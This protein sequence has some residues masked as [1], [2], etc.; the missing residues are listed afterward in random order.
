MAN[1]VNRRDFLKMS[2]ICTLGMALR[3]SGLLKSPMQADTSNQNILIIIFDALTAKNMSLYGY[4]R[5]TM[6]YLEKLADRAVVYHNHYAGGSFTTP[7]TASLLT[8]VMPWTHRAFRHNGEV[9]GSFVEKNIFHAFPEYHRMAYSHN[10]L[11][12]TLL[13][14]FIVDIDEYTHRQKL[15]ITSN[16]VLDFLFFN[17]SDNAYLSWTRAMGKKDEGYSYS[18]FISSLYE[19]YIERKV[20]KYKRDFPRGIPNIYQDNYF[21]LDEAVDWL[22]ERLLSAP[23][24]Y[25]G[26]FHFLPPH[27]PYNTHRDF[28]KRFDLND[29]PLAE[30]PIHVLSEKSSDFNVTRARLKYDKYLAYVDLEFNRLFQLMDRSG[31]L[32]NTW[33]I[34]T[35][36]HGELFE[37]GIIGHTTSVLFDPIVRIP[38]LIFEPGR[39]ERVDIYSPTSA[40]DVFP[41]LLAQMGKPIPGWCEGRVLPPYSGEKVDPDRR[42]FVIQAKQNEPEKPI[43]VNSTMM[44]RGNYKL[45]SYSGYPELDDDEDL[46]ELYNIANDSEELVDLYHVKTG[47]AD[48]LLTELRETLKEKNE[49]YGEIDS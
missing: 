6:P 32:E 34:L 38:L 31:L 43:R 18:L 40:I 37:R 25:L 11:V 44:L 5:Q 14:Q 16:S 33:L 42:I 23:I 7:G 49:P 1:T 46:V 26:Y 28:Y 30:K 20:S 27:A 22:M 36:D 45:V 9:I 47:M 17:D 19:K 15:F 41:T 4:G 8:G 24:P 12:N 2:G 10:P 3:D 21:V 13:Q 48:E 29:L 35:S 39:R